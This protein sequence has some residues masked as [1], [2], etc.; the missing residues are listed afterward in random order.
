MKKYGDVVMTTTCVS[1]DRSLSLSFTHNWGKHSPIVALGLVL[2]P[3]M[4]G[5]SSGSGSHGH[6]DFKSD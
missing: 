5:P 3:S 2:R 4:L 1:S 6:E